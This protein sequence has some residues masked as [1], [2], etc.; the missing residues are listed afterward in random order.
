MKRIHIYLCI[1]CA[2]F[3]L[4]FGC[5]AEDRDNLFEMPEEE[6]ILSDEPPADEDPDAEYE[7]I[8]TT[9]AEG[10]SEETSAGKEAEKQDSAEISDTGIDPAYAYGNMQKNLPAGNFAAYENSIL[11]IHYNGKRFRLYEIEK[12]TL[13][14]VPVC[15]DASCNH[16]SAKCVSLGVEDNLEA[17]DGKIY[18]S[19]YV[20][21]DA[22]TGRYVMQLMQLQ[23]DHFECILKGDSGGF[24]HANHCLYVVTRDQSLLEYPE[25]DLNSPREVLDEYTYYWNTKFGSKIY[26]TNGLDGVYCTDL[27]DPEP[28]PKHLGCP[29]ENGITDGLHIYSFDGDLNLYCSDMN[30]ENTV[31]LYDM[32]VLLS[33]LNFDGEYIYFRY[34]EG[35]PLDTG[36]HC[37]EVYRASMADLSHPEKIAEVPGYAGTIYTVPGYDWI[38]VYVHDGQSYSGVD[39]FQEEE[40]YA[41]KKDGSAQ[42]KLELPEF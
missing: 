24:W 40:I 39:Y 18:A 23:G 30:G 33:S 6:E 19:K 15:R 42:V 35:W 11:F 21:A 14:V 29:G 10:E 32:P 12:E 41:V 1:L 26:G 8:M 22:V 37:N 7:E 36:D 3:F 2:A 28:A 16:Q 34:Y 4:F 25:D 38:F 31:Q 17:Y 27:S 5:K 9:E 20:L 13:T